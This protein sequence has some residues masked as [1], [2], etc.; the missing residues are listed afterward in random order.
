MVH[1]GL[2]LARD[3]DGAT[4]MVEGGIPG[5]DVELAVRFRKGRKRR[6]RR[7]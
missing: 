1:G 4:Y 6:G 5:E 7:H 3:D 2:C